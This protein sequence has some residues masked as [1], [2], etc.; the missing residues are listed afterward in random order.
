MVH[1]TGWAPSLDITPVGCVRCFARAAWKGIRPAI[2]TLMVF[3]TF[4]AALRVL[5]IPITLIHDTRRVEAREMKERMIWSRVSDVSMPPLL[6]G[7]CSTLNRYTSVHSTTP[8]SQ[9]RHRPSNVM[10]SLHVQHTSCCHHVCTQFLAVQRLR[11]YMCIPS[12]IPSVPQSRSTFA[13]V[14]SVLWTLCQETIVWPPESSP[15]QHR[16]R[17]PQSKRSSKRSSLPFQTT[18]MTSPSAH[19]VML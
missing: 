2:D 7:A 4:T 10:A 18:S 14:C 17:V 12:H 3:R 16:P 11:K 13:C 5:E 8:S 9:I 6:A 19:P 15:Q 1:V